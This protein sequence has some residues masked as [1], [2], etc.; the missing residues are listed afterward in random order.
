M[1]TIEH[2]DEQLFL[3]LNSLHVTYLDSLM[4]FVSSYLFWGILFA[5]CAAILF[6]YH[7]SIKELFFYGAGTSLVVIFT[8][9]VKIFIKRPRPIHHEEWKGVIHSIDKY[10]EHYSFFSSHAASVFCFCFFVFLSL[11]KHRWIG[12]IAMLFSFIIAYSRIYVGKHFPGDVLVGAI[13]GLL[14]GWIS[15]MISRK[16][17]SPKKI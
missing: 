11:P 15:W 3:Y 6:Y 14:F 17:F 8:N 5:L 7:R 16:Y 1:K 13:V 2:L 9:V 10:S 4:V 12:Y